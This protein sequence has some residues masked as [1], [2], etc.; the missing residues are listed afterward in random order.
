[1]ISHGVVAGLLFLLVG[2]L[3]ERTHTR[4]LDRCGGLGTVIPGWATVFT[5]GALASLGLPGLSGFPGEFLTTIEGYNAWGWWILP[6]TIG[7]VLA[8]A[9]NL[10]AVWAVNHRQASG[11]W[12][13][14][15][16]L[17]AREWIPVAMLSV[18]ILVLGIWPRIVIDV[19]DATLRA[20]ASGG[21]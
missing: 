1:M 13:G 20:L 6:A 12:A 5:F 15:L 8:A 21:M 14:L 4:E 10:R 19:A 16:D 9:Y 17:S 3:Y 18:A 11:E 2:Q 7:V